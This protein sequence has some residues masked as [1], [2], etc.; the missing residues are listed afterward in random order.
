MTDDSDQH[1]LGRDILWKKRSIDTG[2]GKL[3]N[4]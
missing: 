2:G 4:K 1:L 3:Q